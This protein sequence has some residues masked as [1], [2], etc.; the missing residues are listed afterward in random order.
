MG[1]RFHGSVVHPISKFHYNL[2]R[3]CGDASPHVKQPGDF[4]Q[5][6]EI[7]KTYSANLNPFYGWN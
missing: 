6:H 5:D 4:S 1:I 7:Q 3:H 2:G